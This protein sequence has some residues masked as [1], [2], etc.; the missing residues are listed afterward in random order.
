MHN[1]LNMV[2]KY[3]EKG[4][5]WEEISIIMKAL[6]KHKLKEIHVKVLEDI[7]KKNTIFSISLTVGASRLM[8]AQM[9]LPRLLFGVGWSRHTLIFLSGR[10]S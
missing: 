3:Y 10:C 5:D 2:F 1:T 8:E 4:F 6:R 7:Y 9:D